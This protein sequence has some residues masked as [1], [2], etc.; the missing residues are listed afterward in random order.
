MSQ[1]LRE[2]R[3]FTRIRMSKVPLGLGGPAWSAFA[4]CTSPVAPFGQDFRHADWMTAFRLAEEFVL[5][6]LKV[7]GLEGVG[8]F[9]GIEMPEAVIVVSIVWTPDPATVVDQEITL[10]IKHLVLADNEIFQ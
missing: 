1:R 10:K 4:T 6:H 2:A 9:T 3:A 8:E 7:Y 5:E